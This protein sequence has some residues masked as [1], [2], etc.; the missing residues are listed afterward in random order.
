MSGFS[1]ADGGPQAA[2]RLTQVL[3]RC[4][5]GLVR[6][7]QASQHVPT[8]GCIAVH[9]QVGQQRARRVCPKVGHWSSV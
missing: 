4:R 2:Q 3:V 9:R 6:P 1:I 8:T 7:Q 5:V